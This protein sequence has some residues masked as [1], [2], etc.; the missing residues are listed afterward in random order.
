ME[1]KIAGVSEAAQ[2]DMVVQILA[3]VK[4]MTPTSLFW[5]RSD[6][7]EDYLKDLGINRALLYSPVFWNWY[8][9]IWYLND[10]HLMNK[11]VPMVGKV[12]EKQY[13]HFQKQLFQKHKMPEWILPLATKGH[14]IHRENE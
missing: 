11:I 9:G 14:S 12:S 4:K 7:A 13:R 8:L 10:L 6:S 1:R 5:L 3:N 2:S